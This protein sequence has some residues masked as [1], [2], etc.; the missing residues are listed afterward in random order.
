[1]WSTQAM[2][3]HKPELACFA[4]F[5]MWPAALLSVPLPTSSLSWQPC[6]SVPPPHSSF[7]GGSN[8]LFTSSPYCF[9]S[10][11]TELTRRS[12]PTNDCLTVHFPH[13]SHFSFDGCLDLQLLP[14]PRFILLTRGCSTFPPPG[15]H[16]WGLAPS[17][18]PAA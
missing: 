2:N 18:G 8:S 12:P 11:C 16:S 7:S 5:V 10:P 3:L 15:T 17:T 4:R 14:S 9:P 13:P 6:S 1:M